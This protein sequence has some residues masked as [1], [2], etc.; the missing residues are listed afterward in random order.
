MTRS[1]LINKE[2][3]LKRDYRFI[4]K[5][6]WDFPITKGVLVVALAIVGIFLWKTF[7]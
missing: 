7:R 2:P 1:N 5:E 6:V 4:L 3:R